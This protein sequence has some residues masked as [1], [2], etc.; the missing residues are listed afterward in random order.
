MS[1]LFI[2]F[3]VVCIIAWIFFSVK[4]ISA[5][6][7]PGKNAA[8]LAAVFTGL[9]SILSFLIATGVIPLDSSKISVSN[10]TAPVT[11]SNNYTD[12]DTNAESL[13]FLDFPFSETENTQGAEEAE[14]INNPTKETNDVPINLT[15][16]ILNLKGEIK[17]EDQEDSY[18]IHTDRSG[19][20]RFEISG[21][22]AE[23]KVSMCLKDVGGGEMFRN[24]WIENGEGITANDLE[25]G[26][27]YYVIIQQATGFTPYTLII[28]KQQQTIDINGSKSIG[29][30]IVFTDQVNKYS[31]TPAIC[32]TYRFEVEDLYAE[33]KISMFIIDEGGGVVIQN[34]W[35]ENGE[36]I[37]TDQLQ[38]YHPY[39]ILIQ[40]AQGLSK[41]TL[42]IG[43]QTET[44]NVFA[45]S[46]ET[47]AITF[48][49]QV[50][51]YS[52]TPRTAKQYRFEINDV[53]CGKKVSMLIS[54]QGGGNLEKNT[55]IENGEGISTEQLK[56]GEEYFIKIV[57]ANGC[58][59][60]S[61]IIK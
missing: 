42:K 44:K 18:S 13:T 55:W 19:T 8:I 14:K 29:G 20:Y 47:D 26:K 33:K 9:S 51:I 7:G 1:R 4:S 41:Y 43:Y 31:F 40:Q 46:V 60:Y 37:T 2:A 57:Y 23:K 10:N 38:A 52:F 48:R 28:G 56:V 36:G 24:I 50:N 35:I 54:D 5:K 34:T 21:L 22:N 58:T 11:E 49:D 45:D 59:P 30:E 61:L 39:L 17:K 32:G 12:G 25:A 15:D 3:G 27:T 53:Q 16:V 6:K